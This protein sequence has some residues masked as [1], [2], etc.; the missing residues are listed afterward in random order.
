[1]DN[2]PKHTS[3]YVRDFLK[4]KKVYWWKTPAE[5]PDLNPIEKVMKNFLRNNH[6]RKR[7]P[8]FGWIEEWHQEV[9]EDF[10]T[11]CLSKVH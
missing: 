8:Q 2:D 11:K 3:N 1:M 10:N 9:L 4:T 7:K 5:S 6:F